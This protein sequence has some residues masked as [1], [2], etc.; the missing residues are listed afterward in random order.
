MDLQAWF[1][2]LTAAKVRSMRGEAEGQ[3][4]DCK[5]I[6][7]DNDM[8]KNLARVV[9]GFANG[10]GGVCLWGV[11]A[12]KGT[13]DVD[14]IDSFPGVNDP[15]ATAAR[16]DEL[17]AMACS[18][19]VQGVTH[20]ALSART[21]P[22]FVATF[23]PQSDAG[24][25]MARYSED[26]Y[27]QRIGQS[28]LRMEHFQIADQFG[29]R[30]RPSLECSLEFAGSCQVLVRLTN[31][32][33]GAA[34]APYLRLTASARFGRSQ[35]SE[36]RLPYRG[37]DPDGSWMHAGGADYVIHPGTSVAVCTVWAGLDPSHGGNSPVPPEVNISYSLG[38]LDVA[39]TSGSL[40]QRFR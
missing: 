28:F 20:R 37:G 6:G 12:R 16:L 14:C 22:G 15:R 18:P 34:R 27:F 33:R 1:D 31:S 17:T 36:D 13:D 2:G 8:R 38:A 5:V 10:A 24:P 40:T 19:G 25:H 23:V 30:A 39:P 9:S 32:G 26:R 29:R 35:F 4:L 11:V 21:A 7:N 3:Q